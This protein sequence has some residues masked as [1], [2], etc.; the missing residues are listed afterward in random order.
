MLRFLAAVACHAAGGARISGLGNEANEGGHIPSCAGGSLQLR[1]TY[2]VTSEILIEENCEVHGD[3]ALLLLEK[4]LHF[5]G[6]V[7]FTGVFEFLGVGHVGP[8]ARCVDVEGHASFMQAKAKFADCGSMQTEDGGGLYVQRSLRVRFSRLSFRNCQAEY[9]GGILVAGGMLSMGSELFF[10]FCQAIEGAGV[11]AYGHV[12]INAGQ[13]TFEHGVAKLGG[14]GGLFLKNGSLTTGGHLSF[15]NCTAQTGGGLYMPTE[16]GVL[17]Q[18]G[19]TMTFTDCTS[20][21][22]EGGGLFARDVNQGRAG[23]MH[24]LRCKALSSAGGGINAVHGDLR[25]LATFK[26]VEARY[27]GAIR[28]EETLVLKGNVSIRTSRAQSGGALHAGRVAVKGGVTFVQDA[29]TLIEGAGIWANSL[30]LHSG[31]LHFKDCHAGTGGVIKIL[32]MFRQFSGRVTISNAS[33]SHLGAIAT[34]WLLMESGFI[35]ISNVLIR[36]KDAFG[37]AISSNKGIVI[38]ELATLLI[39]NASSAGPGG[40][41]SA[42]F[43]VSL[44]NLTVKNAEA[45]QAGGALYVRAERFS[46]LLTTFT[47]TRTRSLAVN[48]A[49]RY[50]NGTRTLASIALNLVSLL[51]PTSFEAC[52]AQWGGAIYTPGEV[53]LATTARFVDCAARDVR[54]GAAISAHHVSSETDLFLANCSSPEGGVI[55]ASGNVNLPNVE[56]INSSVPQVVCYNFTASRLRFSGGAGA[57][58][59]GQIRS[60]EEVL[61]DNGL[62]GN[63][64]VY[65]TECRPCRSGYFQF[66]GPVKIVKTTVF[67]HECIKV[68]RASFPLADGLGIRPGFM[69]DR[70]NL[71]LSLH[72]PNQMACPGGNI[73]T[74]GWTPMCVDGYAGHGCAKCNQETHGRAVNDPF[75]CTKCSQSQSM[76]VL[77]WARFVFQHSVLFAVSA[78]GVIFSGQESYKSTILTNQLMSYVAVCM[79]VL[80]TVSNSR[81]FR[82]LTETLQVVIEALSI[83]VDIAN[84]GGSD[85]Q[86]VQCLLGYVGIP[87]TLYNADMLVLLLALFFLLCLARLV[88]MCSA[89]VVTGNCYLPRLCFAFGRHLVCYRMEMERSGGQLVC[90]F[91]EDLSVPRPLAVALVAS[92]FLLGCGSWMY[93]IRSQ[94]H[95]PGIS[96]LTTPYTEECTMWEVTVLARKMLILLVSAVWPST[97]YPAMQMEFITL[98][99]IAALVATLRTDP[100]VSK[101]WNLTEEILL[102]LALLMVTA[103]SCFHANET[104]WARSE[105]SQNFTLL[106]IV[107]LALGPALVMS[108]RITLAL[109]REV[110][111]MFADEVKEVQVI[112]GEKMS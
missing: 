47:D 32:V 12:V 46:T 45:G 64:D 87:K 7:T 41:I 109:I 43:F 98:I 42:T 53:Q 55:V 108:L 48:M 94:I 79:P 25:G 44:G 65:K 34:E 107:V 36:D 100:Y 16:P 39:E 54:S 104:D 49:S 63:V 24:F 82:Q 93:L 66:R 61:C 111:E 91:Q 78:S 73:T 68:P 70:S 10:S 23:R 110:R 92:A 105:A 21:M 30:E 112:E 17:T 80:S 22:G 50:L 86:S 85:G 58:L 96:Y 90:G 3:K 71:S 75:A 13:A 15:K 1:G 52:R 99:L 59:L 29:S 5:L 95:S 69:V 74:N 101:D 28:V 9:G 26:K 51:G 33:G 27:G 8:Q 38:G 72:C 83:P 37:G 77:Q 84:S 106:V 14:G 4:P 19:G 11:F 56:F 97:L 60:T 88:D 18:S 81:S 40:A 103:T 20:S 76:K 57:M 67:G 35:Q 2:K 102:V 62:E 6:N 89:I 31:E